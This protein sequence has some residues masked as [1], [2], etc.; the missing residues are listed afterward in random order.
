MLF[1]EER[2]YTVKRVKDGFKWEDIE[3]AP[4]DRYCWDY[5][6]EPVAYG[7]FVFLN[8][9]EFIAKLTCFEKDPYAKLSKYGEEAWTD[10][11]LEF[12]AAFDAKRPD[13]F[14]NLEMASKGAA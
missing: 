13:F 8:E 9:K 4:I 6:Y 2:C 7:Q 12:C 5:G 10:S 3:K 1:K 11:C 14:A